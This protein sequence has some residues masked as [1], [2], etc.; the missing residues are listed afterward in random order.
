[1]DYTIILKQFED[2]RRARAK[3]FKKLKAKGW[4][5]QRIGA[6]EVPPIS[7]ERVRQLLQETK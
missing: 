4:T 3:K 5:N 1:M 7:A 2:A 6:A